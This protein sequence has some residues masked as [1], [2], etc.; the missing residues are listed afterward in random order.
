[1]LVAHLFFYFT[2]V[3]AERRI[4]EHLVKALAAGTGARV[5][6]RAHRRLG[7]GGARPI[8][9]DFVRTLTIHLSMEYGFSPEKDELLRRRRGISFIDVIEVLANDG[10][11]SD[12]EHPNQ[13]RYPGQRVYVIALGGYAYCVPYVRMGDVVFLKTAFP[14]RKFKYLLEEANDE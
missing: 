6:D 5:I 11:L 14:S 12:F 2:L 8:R 10:V 13:E 3:H 4:G 7:G 1:M 9:I